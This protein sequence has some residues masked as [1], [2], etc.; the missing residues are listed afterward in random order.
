VLK[1]KG[2]E[3]D[4]LAMDVLFQLNLAHILTPIFNLISIIATVNGWFV[5]SK[6]CDT[7]SIFQ[8]QVTI[9]YAQYVQINYKADISQGKIGGKLTDMNVWFL[10]EIM[11]FYG[12][13][14]SAIYYI[15]EN[16]IRSS[17]G[18]KKPE[19]FADRFKFDFLQYHK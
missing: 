17:L 10:I 15:A 3:K 1:G 14:F 5:L 18:L 19:S 4:A 2:V 6:I 7:I 13:I 16:Q 8:Y 11:S 12:Y 9:F